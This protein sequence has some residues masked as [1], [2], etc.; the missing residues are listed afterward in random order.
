MRVEDDGCRQPR[1]RGPRPPPGSRPRPANRPAP[2]PTWLRWRTPGAPAAPSGAPPI[3]TDGTSTSTLPP[4][5]R[6]SGSPTTDN[7]SSM[8]SVSGG[9]R[10]TVTPGW[11]RSR[12]QRSVDAASAGPAAAGGGVGRERTM[13]AERRD[14]EEE[15]GRSG[16]TPG[17]PLRQLD[18][19]GRR[20]PP[21]PRLQRE[22][23][24]AG[25]SPDI[26]LDDPA[27]H[28]PTVERCPHA[29][30]G[31][32]LVAPTGR[33]RIVERLGH[34]GHLGAHAHHTRRVAVPAVLRHA[35]LAT[36]RR[37]P[38]GERSLDQ[39]PNSVRRSSTR[40]VASHV[41]SFS[42]RPK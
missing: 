8:G 14:P 6:T 23:V 17:R 12:S 13:F 26:L 38:S 9:S 32:H 21:Q 31:V 36:G 35:S 18:Q 42:E 34:C 19:G 33:H 7:T 25:G 24:D 2:A 1:A 15:R 30:A 20:P 39:S 4:R 29:S 16:P 27:P 41:N 37:P 5:A 28:R 11:A 3:P 22:E 10:T 40:G